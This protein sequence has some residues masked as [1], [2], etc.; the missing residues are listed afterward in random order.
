MILKHFIEIPLINSNRFP[1]ALLDKRKVTKPYLSYAIQSYTTYNIFLCTKLVQ[2]M[3]WKHFD[4]REDSLNR[5]LTY[6]WTIMSIESPAQGVLLKL[7]HS[8]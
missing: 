5:K 2:A 8:F 4:E 6:M 1:D 3:I 7:S